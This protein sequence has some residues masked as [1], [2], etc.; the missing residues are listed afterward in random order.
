[1]KGGK[2]GKGETEGK[3]EGESKELEKRGRMVVCGS[4]K[5]KW[6]FRRFF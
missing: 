6:D 2:Q 3:E 4:G 5:R 1:V